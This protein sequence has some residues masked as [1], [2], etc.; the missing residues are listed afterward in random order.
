MIVKID[1]SLKIR[2]LVALRDGYL[3][4]SQFPELYEDDGSQEFDLRFLSEEEQLILLKVG[5]KALNEMPGK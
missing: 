1:R 2:L 3:N 5:E 4:T